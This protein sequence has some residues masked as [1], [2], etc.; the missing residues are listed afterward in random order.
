MSEKNFARMYEKDFNLGKYI[1]QW[2]STYFLIYPAIRLFYRVSVKGRE[3]IPKNQKFIFAPNHISFLDPHTV[4]IATNRPMAYMAKTEL[5]K[6]KFLQWVIPK[7]GG[8]AVNREKLEVATIKTVR[9]VMKTKYFNLCIFPQG[10]IFRNKKIEVINRGFA[11]IAKMS[12][13]DIIPMA[14]TGVEK[15]NWVPFKGHLNVSIGTPISWKLSETEIYEQ[16]VRQVC[17][18][19]GYEYIP[20]NQEQ[21]TKETETV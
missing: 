5:F 11:V 15:Y 9:D 16:W 7:L 13:T 18:M 6:N 1:I 19:A 20:D 10:G 21:E 8:F 2:T 3:N 14:I 17:S 4:F 12:K